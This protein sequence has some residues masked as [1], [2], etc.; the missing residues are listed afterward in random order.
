M[1]IIVIITDPRLDQFS[2]S[3]SLDRYIVI[4]IITT[5]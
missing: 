3:G 2:S 1:S 4:I 5:D